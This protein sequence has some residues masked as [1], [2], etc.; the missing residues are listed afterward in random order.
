MSLDALNNGGTGSG[1][2]NHAMSGRG[3]SS[4]FQACTA[5]SGSLL[6]PHNLCVVRKWKSWTELATLFNVAMVPN[7]NTL[8]LD[9]FHR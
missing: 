8:L 9:F 2:N 6:V 3:A 5:M 4:T 1:G 7:H